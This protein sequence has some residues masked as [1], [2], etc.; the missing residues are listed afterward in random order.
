[1][2]SYQLSC[3]SHHID[4]VKQL[5]SKQH[6]TLGFGAETTSSSFYNESQKIQHQDC[7][8]VCGF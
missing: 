2:T 3:L 4:T 5:S 6:C 7:L 8:M 1:M